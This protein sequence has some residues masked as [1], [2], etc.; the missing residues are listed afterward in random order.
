M[1]QLTVTIADRPSLARYPEGTT[2]G[3]RVLADFELVWIV[4]GSA[5]WRCARGCELAL[6]PGDVL[7]IEPGTEDEF[8]WDRRRP[9]RHGYVHFSVTGGWPEMKAGDW[10]RCRTSQPLDPFGAMLDYL[11]WLAEETHSGWRERAE[12][13]LAVLVRT[14]I[15]GP[16]PESYRTAEAAALTAALD[17][18]RTVWAETVRPI[19]LDE[20]AAA[21]AVTKSYLAR[22]FRREYGYGLVGALE[23]IRLER[24]RTLLERTNLNISQVA[25]ASG[26]ADPLHFSRR[27]HAKLG[28]SPREYRKAPNAFEPLPEELR[29]LQRRLDAE[30]AG[31]KP[32]SPGP[33]VRR[34]IADPD[35]Y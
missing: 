33:R 8:R 21:A 4:S 28:I 29:R 6:R 7:L 30:R 12:D 3:P 16:L 10:S 35:I 26:F 34:R 1:N 15:M 9:S 24:A 13:I 5:Q 19:G 27:F 14:L 18:V 17:H 20:L 11:L 22:R 31:V 25:H 2:Y 32:V 23:L